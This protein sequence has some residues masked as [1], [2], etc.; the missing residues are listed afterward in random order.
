MTFLFT[1]TSIVTAALLF[2]VQPMVARMVLPAFGGSPQVWT[3]AMLFFQTAL[4]AGYS[5]THLATNRLSRRVQLGLHCV[6]LA[7]PLVLLP[8]AM[9]V[10]PSGRGGIAPSLE[11]LFA[12][13]LGVAAPFIVIATSGP[14][15]QR[16]FSWTNHRFAHDPYFLYAAGNIGSIGGLLAYPFLIEPNF[17]I[18]EQSQLWTSGYWLAGGLLTLCAI[19]VSSGLVPAHS[20]PVAEKNISAPIVWSRVF[21]WMLLAFIPSSLLLGV[22]A[23]LATD[24]ASIPMLWIFPL[25]AYLLTFAIAFSRWGAHALKLASW[26]APAVILGALVFRPTMLGTIPVI[27]IQVGLVFV[28]GLI[29]HGKLAADR[30]RTS[31][32]TRFYLILSI[33]GALGGLFNTLIAPLIFPH[34]FEYGLILTA[35]LAL[36]T[37]WDSMVVGTESCKPQLR[38][39]L[40]VFLFFLPILAVL[41]VS[42]RSFLNWL[43]ETDWQAN[44]L[45]AALVFPFFWPIGRSAIL[46]I[47]IAIASV[48]TQGLEVLTAESVDRTFFGVHRVA[49][50]VKT[51]RLMLSHGTTNHGSQDF[52]SEQSRQEPRVYYQRSGPCGDLM[53]AVSETADLGVVGLGAGTIAAYGT[54]LRSV[55]FHEID[56]TIIRIAEN[57]F[58]YLKDGRDRGSK[59]QIVLGDGRLTLQ[60]RLNAYDL[61]IID[62]FSS[63]SIPVHL[64]TLEGIEVYLKATKSDGMIALHVSNRYL[65]LLPVLAGAAEELNLKILQRKVGEKNSPDASHW[66][67]I[68]KSPAE[69]EA[70]KQQ[71]WQELPQRK[72]V[73]TDQR[74]SL[75]AIRK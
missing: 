12:L 1:L 69:E 24:V 56:P 32:L 61:L 51:N 38:A 41:A 59:I 10:Q 29:G 21:H 50:D 48:L 25:V 44:L 2:L 22:T 8:I 46:C 75:W 67:V 16:W 23:H 72:I 26:L 74:S 35:T 43:P 37:R 19:V 6:V 7:L 63:D 3:T 53:K 4:L 62:A 55:T 64:L 28:G 13:T 42:L 30:P 31:E 60:D 17:S 70:L 9:K 27:A 45:L 57:Q 40:G 39:V 14:L 11:L 58:A 66:A 49:R 33:G 54:P 52:T 71:G 36:V 18:V 47:G 15:V 34:V 73:W 5:Y 68:L 65:D 20:A